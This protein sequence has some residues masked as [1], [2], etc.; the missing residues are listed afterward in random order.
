MIFL[1]IE[2]V[3]ILRKLADELLEMDEQ[4]AIELE[5]WPTAAAF[6]KEVRV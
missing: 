3:M 6:I 2:Q 5:L 1:T 4:G